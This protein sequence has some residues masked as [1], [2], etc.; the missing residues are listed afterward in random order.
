MKSAL[1]LEQKSQL[2]SAL[3]ASSLALDHSISMCKEVGYNELAKHREEV[4]T[5]V[6]AALDML[7][8]I[9]VLPL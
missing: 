8:K 1:S 4:R 3:F 2:R 5:R 7:E 6:N 9:Y